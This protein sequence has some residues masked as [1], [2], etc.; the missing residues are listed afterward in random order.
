MKNHVDIITDCRNQAEF[1]LKSTNQFI[2]TLP[3]PVQAGIWDRPL[4]LSHSLSE[5]IYE[6]SSQVLYHAQRLEDC[7]ADFSVLIQTASD[8]ELLHSFDRLLTE[9]YIFREE[10]A[11]Y[12]NVSNT[13]LEEENDVVELSPLYQAADLLCK[14]IECFIKKSKEIFPHT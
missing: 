9:Y 1:F 8:I 10:I 6:F 11:N 12:L 14:K 2:E 13:Y 7:F 5:S 4:K 3:K